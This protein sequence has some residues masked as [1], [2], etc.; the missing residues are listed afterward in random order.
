MKNF[1]IIVHFLFFCYSVR[2]TD[3]LYISS[4]DNSIHV[5][6]S[7]KNF[8]TYTISVDNKIILKPSVI[9]MEL[10]NGKKLSDD[11]AIRSKNTHSVNAIITSPFPE[12]R[13]NV[14]D[15]YNELIIQFKQNFGVV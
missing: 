15:I 7:T 5:T 12:I 4:P 8:F 1:L 3:T 13:K 9:D 2:A 14:P 10:V 6:I 11:L